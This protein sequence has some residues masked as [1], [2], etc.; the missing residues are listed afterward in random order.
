MVQRYKNGIIFP[1]KNI[2][3]SIGKKMVSFFFL[4]KEMSPGTGNNKVSIRKKK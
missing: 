4:Q 2:E 3:I 1:K